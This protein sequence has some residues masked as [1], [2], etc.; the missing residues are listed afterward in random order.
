MTPPMT[1]MPSGTEVRALADTERDRH[2]P[3]DERERCHQDRPQPD[4]AGPNQRLAPVHAQTRPLSEVIG[5][6]MA[7]VR[8]EVRVLASTAMTRSRSR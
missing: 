3:G 7:R 6:I 4:G 2:H 1:A 8:Q 5:D